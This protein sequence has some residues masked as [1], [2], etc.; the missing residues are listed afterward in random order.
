MLRPLSGDIGMGLASRFT[1]GSAVRRSVVFQ[2]VARACIVLPCAALGCGG[3]GALIIV[4][5]ESVVEGEATE[6]S[7]I[8]GDGARPGNGS[9][10]TSSS[11]NDAENVPGSAPRSPSESGASAARPA[12]LGSSDGASGEV[13]PDD[14]A[15]AWVFDEA[16]VH[17]YELTLDPA[18]WA[19][20]QANARD[21]EY[22]EADFRANGQTLGRIGLRFKGSLGT[23]ASCFEDDGTPRCS[24][25]SMK[26]RFDEYQPEQRFAGLKRLNFN[27]MLF[28][29]SL[30]HERLAYRVFREMG[31]IAPRAVHARLVIN[32][33]DQGL[34]A[35]VEDVDG[36]FT[37]SHFDDG[38]G[39]LYKEA[40]PS[41][42]DAE[43][44]A[45]ALETNEELA[46]N[47]GFLQFQADLLGAAPAELPAVLERYVDV[48]Q[49]LT[50]LAVDQALVNWD[51]I[52]AFYCY[53][54]F[55]ENHNYFWYEDEAQPRF[56]LIPWD[57]DNTFEPSP[58]AAVPSVF[59]IRTDCSVLY[60]EMGRTVRAPGCDPMLQGLVLSGAAGYVSALDR[61]LDGP[62]APGILEGWIDELEAQ[63]LREVMTDTR[64]PSL[65]SFQAEVERLRVAVEGLREQA[66]VERDARR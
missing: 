22:A 50:Y 16:A 21:E 15:R 56:R 3:D 34:F 5:G 43:I 65:E 27:S 7:M 8:D 12:S 52:T 20:L 24:K 32:G 25:M 36:R 29:D 2:G 4:P 31:V 1:L 39:N 47:A 33:D 42:A 62:F 11:G 18:V 59:D 60:M 19:A 23:L 44:L 26:L 17:T 6:P 54:G 13:I 63:L 48:D 14:A 45:S 49:M 51:G 41:N 38:D 46:N 10:V 37:K 53:E 66:E 35:L 9:G 40:W 61:L 57:L 28:D 55:C 58:L 64:G 30:M